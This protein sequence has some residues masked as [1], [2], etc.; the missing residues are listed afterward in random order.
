M[1]L[2]LHPELPV[3]RDEAFQRAMHGTLSASEDYLRRI[4][5][6]VRLFGIVWILVPIVSAA[7]VLTFFIGLMAFG[8]GTTP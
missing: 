3:E 7:A 6:W 4:H 1:A 2:P 8:A 5:W